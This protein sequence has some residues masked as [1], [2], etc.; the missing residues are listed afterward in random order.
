LGA[1]LI[2][3]GVGRAVEHSGW[4]SGIMTELLMLPE[5][6]AAIVVMTNDDSADIS[7]LVARLLEI[8]QLDYDPGSPAP[9]LPSSEWD[10]YVGE[11]ISREATFGDV[12]IER[13]GDDL[14]VIFGAFDGATSALSPWARDQFVVTM[15]ADH[16]FAPGRQMLVRFV[17]TA[18]GRLHLSTRLGAATRAAL[19]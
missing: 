15:P 7:D 9:P 2:G 6:E 13:D 17:P 3:E 11:F 18:D 14:R 4:Q 8:Y 1:F 16:P 19:P 5:Q 12:S 10:S